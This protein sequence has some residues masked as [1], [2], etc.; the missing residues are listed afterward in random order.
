MTSAPEP[1]A[2][3]SAHVGQ[4]LEVHYRWHPYFRRK[5]VIRRIAQRA[6]GRL[7]SI[8]GRR[9]WLCS[10]I[11]TPFRQAAFADTH[12]MRSTLLTQ[13]QASEAVFR[14]HVEPPGRSTA[15]R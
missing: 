8:M 9:A 3:H 12:Q 1:S 13:Q 5:V 6:T 7:L 10:H 15:D 4:E 11:R 2:V 14:N